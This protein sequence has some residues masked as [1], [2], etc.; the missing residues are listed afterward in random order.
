MA[1]RAATV[2]VTLVSEIALVRLRVGEVSGRRVVHHGLGNLAEGGDQTVDQEEDQQ[3]TH[4]PGMVAGS[5]GWGQG[6]VGWL[7]PPPMKAMS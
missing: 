3:E 5:G 6:M 1:G 2:L 7:R 4:P